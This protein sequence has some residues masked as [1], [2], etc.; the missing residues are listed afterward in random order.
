M[1]RISGRNGRVLL[2]IASVSAEAS[3]LP[4][5]ATYGMN[6]TTNKIDVTVMGDLNKVYLSGLKDASGAFSGFFDD[7]TNQTY[8]AA[9]DGQSRKFYLYPNFDNT[10]LY[11]Y[12]RII[13]DMNIDAN[14]DGATSMSA[15]WSA[16]SDIWKY[17][18]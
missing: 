5:V 12:G 16:Y 10:L 6:F 9:T 18:A 8:T 3:A 11:F 15:N 1:G 17:P 7:V 2:G 14:V 4:F 13:V